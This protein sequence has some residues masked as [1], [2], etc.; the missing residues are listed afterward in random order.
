MSGHGGGGRV[1][2]VK[3]ARQRHGDLHFDVDVGGRGLA[4]E[5]FDEGVGHDLIPAAGV[6]EGF[7]G[8]GVLTLSVC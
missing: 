8:V 1:V 5:A 6:A 4:G 7:G 3:Q 2:G